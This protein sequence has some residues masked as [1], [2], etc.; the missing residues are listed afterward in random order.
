M[1][2]ASCCPWLNPRV[3][4]QACRKAGEERKHS[5]GA[6]STSGKDDLL[7]QLSTRARRR[8]QLGADPTNEAATDSDEDRAIKGEPRAPWPPYRL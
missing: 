2:P 8:E 1:H 7:R 6:A 5:H 3:A 4:W